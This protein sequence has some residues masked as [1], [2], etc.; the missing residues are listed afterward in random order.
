MQSKD[1][2]NWIYNDLKYISPLL[3]Q[4]FIDHT[5]EFHVRSL[6]FLRVIPYPQTRVESDTL[7]RTHAHTDITLDIYR[8]YYCTKLDCTSVYTTSVQLDNTFTHLRCTYFAW[9][10]CTAVHLYC[11]SVSVRLYCKLDQ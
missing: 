1:Q 3:M 10:S 11:S 7:N 9:I 5:V 4:F 8:F 2:N 6:N